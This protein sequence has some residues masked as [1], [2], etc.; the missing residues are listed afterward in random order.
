MTTAQYLR[1]RAQFG[2]RAV[3]HAPGRPIVP[4]GVLEGCTRGVADTVAAAHAKG[5]RIAIFSKVDNAIRNV[6]AHELGHAVGLKH[7][8]GRHIMNDDGKARGSYLNNGFYGNYLQ[9]SKN[10]VNTR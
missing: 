4:L 9:E 10:K 3:K 1:R 7:I 6:V 2:T 8:P 5:A